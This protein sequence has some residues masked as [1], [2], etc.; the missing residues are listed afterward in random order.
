MRKIYKYD[1]AYSHC[2]ITT[3]KAPIEQI[4]DVQWQSHNGPVL[5]AIVDD[6]KE[7]QELNIIAIGTGLEIPTEVEDYIGTLQTPSGYV[8]H[9]FKFNINEMLKAPTEEE[10]AALIDELAALA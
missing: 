7:E 4:L 1:L 10:K 9:Y 6:E 2:D 3:I 8:W 5:W